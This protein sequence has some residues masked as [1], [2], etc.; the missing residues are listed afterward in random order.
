MSNSDFGG[1]YNNSP[2]K[3]GP[4]QAENFGDFG[5]PK[6]R[7]LKGKTLKTGPKKVTK[8]V[9]I[10]TPQIQILS[11]NYNKRGILGLKFS[12]GIATKSQIRQPKD[13]FGKYQLSAAIN[14][15]GLVQTKLT[16]KLQ[17]NIQIREN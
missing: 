15:M 8:I 1:N 5:T 9:L 13:E 11:R 12:F 2:I 14:G 6:M 3:F 7:F 17:N 10:K 4:P 16:I